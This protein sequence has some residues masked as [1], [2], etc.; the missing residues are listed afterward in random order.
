LIALLAALVIQTAEA[1]AEFDQIA[2]LIASRQEAVET[3][4]Q[5]E[6]LPSR[7]YE[8]PTEIPLNGCLGEFIEG[9]T[10]ICRFDP[11]AHVSIGEAEVGVSSDGFAVLAI[12]RQAPETL[13]LVV[14]MRGV[15]LSETR[16]ITQRE[17]NLQHVDGVPQATV[18][19]DPSTLPRRQREYA[20]KQAAF[21]S[22]WDGQG[23]LD[24]FIQPAEGITTGVYGSAR[25]Y[26]DGHEGSPHWGL[27]WANEPGTPVIAPAGGRVVLAEADMYYEGGLIFIDHGQ[28]LVSAFLHMSAVHVSEGDTVE[29]GELIGE[30]GA[31]GRATGPHLDWRVKLRN[32]FYVDPGLLLELDLS[33]LRD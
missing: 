29:Q 16:T 27:D 9:G 5:P 2:E 19:P 6:G 7:T 18:T 30:I 26:N 21:N 15:I 22:V 24:G 28:G 10:L 4:L 17:Y 23:F 13:D 25:V 33:G 8:P 20:Q 32:G 1:P 11:T 14:S 3:E 12:P 31:G